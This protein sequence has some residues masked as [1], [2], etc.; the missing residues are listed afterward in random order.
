MKVAWIARAPAPYR[1][2]VWRE[3]AEDFDLRVLFLNGN[4]RNRR[5]AV[6]PEETFHQTVFRSLGIPYRDDRLYLLTGPLGPRLGSPDVVLFQGIWENPAA[7][8]VLRWAK[9]HPAKTAL[10]YESTAQ[11]TRH[12]SGPVG[13]ARQRFMAKMDAII[14]PGESATAA[15]RRNGIDDSK[16]CTSVNAVDGDWFQKIATTHRIDSVEGH[17][18]IVVAQ[19]IRRKRVDL[20]I[21]AFAT[22]R[23]P[24]DRLLIVG[25]GK[26]ENALRELVI[27]RRLQGFVEFQ[28][29]LTPEQVAALYGKAQTLVLSSEEEVWG[30]VANEAL[31][32]GLHVVVTRVCGVAD[33]ISHMNGVWVADL[34]VDSLRRA[35][36][37][38]R[39]AWC[40][41]IEK[42]EILSLGTSRFA[43]DVRR[44]LFEVANNS[45]AI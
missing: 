43:A 13:W 10:F 19:L 41:W 15:V 30:L 38:S 26:E 34:N 31:A 25:G 14:T 16:I 28:G 2:P 42:P 8:Q 44:T 35:M 39:R 12:A 11:S 37:S 7:W 32:A 3:L 40:G 22:M 36:D 27:A 20:A 9:S 21:E 18:Y 29:H 23:E 6:K 1:Y 45:P 33:S 24:L 5:W 17:T 4:S